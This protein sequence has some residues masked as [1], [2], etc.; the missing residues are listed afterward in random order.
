MLWEYIPISRNPIELV[1]IKGI[2]KREKAIQVLTIEQTQE[3]IKKLPE[4]FN[5]MVMVVSMLGLRLSEMLALQWNDVDWNQKTV[6]IKR[7]SYRGHV[8]TAKTEASHAVLPLAD[9][10]AAVLL[11]WQR[12]ADHESIWM[13]PN[14][15][16]GAPYS[17]PSIQQRWLRPAGEEMGIK[18]LGFHALRHSY[19]SWL[20][21]AGTPMGVM[22]DLMRHSAISVTMNVYGNTLSPEKRQYNEQIVSRL[23]GRD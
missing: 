13:F 4:P 3:L 16:T 5:L 1:K 6:T 11:E 2:T 19:K 14:P 12:K 21:A 20:D 10:L 9:S 15:A 22:K 17:G 23:A 8:D 7:S 18:G